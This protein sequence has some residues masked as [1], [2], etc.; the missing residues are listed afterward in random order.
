MA[1]D[2]RIR[3]FG[4]G[5][6]S[7]KTMYT[8]GGV[9]WFSH[10]LCWRQWVPLQCLY[11]LVFIDRHYRKGW[12]CT[13]RRKGLWWYLNW[14]GKFQWMLIS[15]YCVGCHNCHR[16]ARTALK[17]TPHAESYKG[18]RGLEIRIQVALNSREITQSVSCH[19]TKESHNSI[20]LPTAAFDTRTLVGGWGRRVA[21]KKRELFYIVTCCTLSFRCDRS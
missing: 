1:S 13:D 2:P 14:W 4:G 16:K 9:P 3:S 12:G 8:W 17:K 10:L 19:R 6:F 11:D 20:P 18:D 21:A 15:G 5:S 7:I